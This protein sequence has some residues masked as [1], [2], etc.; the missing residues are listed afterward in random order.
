MDFV[1]LLERG[2]CSRNHQI[3]SKKYPVGCT[4][5]SVVLPG[6]S[7][8][9]Q[10]HA[11]VTGFEGLVSQTTGLIVRMNKGLSR[12]VFICESDKLSQRGQAFLL[13]TPCGT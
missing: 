8:R 1:G 3:P 4:S 10:D 12:H 6:N 2:E 5:K 9:F 11:Y 7:V 13:K